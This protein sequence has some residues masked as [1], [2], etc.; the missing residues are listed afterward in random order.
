MGVYVKEPKSVFFHVA[1]TGGTSIS[2]WMFHNTLNA[3]PMKRHH[4]TPKKFFTDEYPNFRKGSF[5]FCAVRNPWDRLYSMYMYLKRRNRLL[6][7][8]D[9]FEIF[10]LSRL[11]G[12]CIEPQFS[13]SQVCDY[14]LQFEQL[15]E[16]FKEIQK[17]YNCY[18]PLGVAKNVN[19][20]KEHYSKFYTQR[21]IDAVAEKHK[22]DIDTYR[23]DYEHKY[24]FE[25]TI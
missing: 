9:T 11:W 1:K 21:M 6:P 14:V 4:T 13:Y 20:M 18:E 24:D 7:N 3:K 23:Y 15:E 25:R 5:K 22:I 8:H 12:K 17:F 10:I 16:D 19:K 2:Q